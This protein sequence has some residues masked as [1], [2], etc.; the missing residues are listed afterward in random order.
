MDEQ[1]MSP[2][3]NLRTPTNIDNSDLS[4]PGHELLFL[5]LGLALYLAL[6]K[7]VLTFP[8][9]QSSRQVTLNCTA[10]SCQFTAESASEYS[11]HLNC[12]FKDQ[13]EQCNRLSCPSCSQE[14]T[15]GRNWLRHY[16]SSHSRDLPGPY[17]KQARRS[18]PSDPSSSSPKENE[19]GDAAWAMKKMQCQSQGQMEVEKEL[20]NSSFDFRVTL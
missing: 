19:S 9:P 2:S 18:K 11:Q 12:H 4:F 14:F 10:P 17:D 1:G 15:T 8:F 16:A 6:F 20:Q 7:H 13:S 3:I 5:P